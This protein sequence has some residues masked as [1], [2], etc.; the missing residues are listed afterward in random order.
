MLIL[1][2]VLLLCQDDAQTLISHLLDRLMC[3]ER[4]GER[5]G[6][7]F[8]LAGVVKGFGISSLKKYGVT[9]ALRGAL[10]DRCKFLLSTCYISYEGCSFYHIVY[11][12]SFNDSSWSSSV[13]SMTSV[14]RFL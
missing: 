14:S 13:V 10:E 1:I 11:S 6:A 5:R 12:V 3:G 7:A 4:Y 9:S 8:G 2:F